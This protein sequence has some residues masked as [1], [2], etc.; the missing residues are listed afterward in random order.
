MNT[1][2]G[3]QAFLSLT[4][5]LG[6][7]GFSATI[8]SAESNPHEELAQRMEFLKNPAFGPDVKYSINPRSRIVFPHIANGGDS[9]LRIA[10]TLSLTNVG[11]EPI[12]VILEFFD[13]IGN[14]LDLELINSETGATLNPL[15]S[16]FYHVPIEGYKTVFVETTGTGPLQAGWARAWARCENP[17][18]CD[19]SE[20]YL[21][22]GNLSFRMIDGPSGE[23]CSIVGIGASIATPAFSTPVVRDSSKE[24]N[25]AIAFVNSSNTTTYMEVF[26]IGNDG[27]GRQGMVELEP[28]VHIARYVD[29]LF[30]GLGD[31]YHGTLHI[32]QVDEE[33]N[34][35]PRFDVHPVSLLLVCGIMTSV[36]VTNLL[37]FSEPLDPDDVYTP[38]DLLWPNLAM[39]RPQGWSD[40]I[41]VSTTTGTTTD[42]ASFT[43]E[44]TLYV[45]H[46]ITNNGDS[47]IEVEFHTQLLVDGV[48]KASWYM[49]PPFETGMWG[50]A[51]DY[52]IG[53]LAKGTHTI[54]IKIDYLDEV[55]E[56]DETDNTY[57]K[58]IVIGDDAGGTSYDGT[59]SGMTGQQRPLE[60]EVE[61]NHVTMV[62][63]DVRV[64]GTGCSVTVSGGIGVSPGALITNDSFTWSASSGFG[65]TTQTLTGTFSSYSSAS[66]TLT[67]TTGSPCAGT[68]TT[69]WTAQKD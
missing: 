48:P 28:G 11:E 25:T 2:P 51:R 26:L 10:T 17:L 1:Y 14:R 15:S 24:T 34:V 33:G 6:M 56:S 42:S 38:P 35:D 16:G 21:V 46:A 62:T 60:F 63:L 39:Y 64:Q 12:T 67:V 59:W 4:F 27:S 57:T 32:F 43:T 66:G 23:Y 68:A 55:A 20:T 47:D 30:P 37:P 31:P 29:E 65:G 40:S 44:D 41:V 36:P 13:E 3:K 19:Q 22:G 18:W 52:S 54:T 50:S 53:K 5:L 45:D 7:I 61:D 49:E 9:T 58:T 69:T 8:V